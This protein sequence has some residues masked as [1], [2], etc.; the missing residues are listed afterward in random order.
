[1]TTSKEEAAPPSAAKLGPIRTVYIIRF[2]LTTH[3]T[4]LSLNMQ[5][6]YSQYYMMIP[7]LPIE[8]FAPLGSRNWYRTW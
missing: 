5:D 1:M 7:R 6:H 4:H 2:Y 8:L 3:A